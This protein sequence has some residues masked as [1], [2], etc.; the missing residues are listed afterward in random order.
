MNYNTLDAFYLIGIEIRT[1]NKNDQSAT[2]IPKLWNRFME[3]GTIEKIPNKVSGDIYCVY[4]D[5]EG[6]YTQPYTTIIGCK[7][8]NLDNLPFGFRGI[9]INKNQYKKFMAT[10]NL[11]DNVI[12]KEWLKIWNSDIDRS[13]DTDF[14]VYGEK[15][16]NPENV[17]VDI[18][19][20][21]KQTI[22]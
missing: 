3:E 7:V 21:V 6:D 19:V 13:Y 9:A 22:E 8:S 17:E 20:S 10:G 5:Y 16:Q 12:W 2:D 18:F 15:A 14:E 1:S 11:K 4:T